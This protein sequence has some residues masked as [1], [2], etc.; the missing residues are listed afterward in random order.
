MKITILTAGT[1][2]D[3]QPYL[4]LAI[5]MQRA[6]YEV[7]LAAPSNFESFVTSHGISFVPLRADYYQLMDSP[8]GQALKSGNPIRVMQN[9]RT[10]VF[11][12]MRKLLDDTWQ[13]A[14]GTGPSFIIRSYSHLRILPRS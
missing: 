8:E 13:A 4:A 7:V 11:P 3:V 6:G 14:Q 2:G 5:T 10:T 9:M 1:R 12:M